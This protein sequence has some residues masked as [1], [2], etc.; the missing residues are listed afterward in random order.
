MVSSLIYS[1]YFYNNRQYAQNLHKQNTFSLLLFF[2]YLFLSFFP[3][4]LIIFTPFLLSFLPLFSFSSL[5]STH[6]L[7]SSFLFPLLSLF[8]FSVLSLPTFYCVPSSFTAFLLLITPT[9]VF[10]IS[11]SLCCS[12]SPASITSLLLSFLHLWSILPYLLDLYQQ[13]LLPW[14]LTTQKQYLPKVFLYKY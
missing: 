5:F 1:P 9:I 8:F 11:I 3:I 7:F 10:V 14:H 6:C 4:F 2:L 12:P 13:Y